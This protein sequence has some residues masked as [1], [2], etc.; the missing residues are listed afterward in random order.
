MKTTLACLSSAICLSML[1]GCGGH[2]LY[3]WRGYDTKLYEH[4]KNPHEQQKFSED[5]KEVVVRAEAEG[6]VPPGIYA[7]YGF[8]LLEQG[9][10]AA[11]VYYFQKEGFRWPE[12][13]I[14]M[15]KL[16][17]V[18]QG[19]FIKPTGPAQPQPGYP[20]QPQPGY[21]AQPQPGAL[22]PPASGPGAATTRPATTG[23]Q[24]VMR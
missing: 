6:R 2:T 18:A 14:L 8:L 19:R 23:T 10:R 9:N 20:A 1:A 15:N 3:E 13:R 22:A 4:Y 7:E 12:S 17:A 21:P 5:M 24:E 11:A 16:I